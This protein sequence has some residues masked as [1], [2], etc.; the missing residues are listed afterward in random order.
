MSVY[1]GRF[2]Y[3]INNSYTDL[4]KLVETNH[5]GTAS[6]ENL[7]LSSYFNVINQSNVVFTTTAYPVNYINNDQ[8]VGFLS[9]GYIDLAPAFTDALVAGTSD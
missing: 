7:K 2:Y 9:G 8:S 5:S 3:K 1:E 6:I 4:S